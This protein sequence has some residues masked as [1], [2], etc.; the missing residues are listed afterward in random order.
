VTQTELRLLKASIDKR[1]QIETLDG[2]RMI[3]KVISVFDEGSDADLFYELV[4][5]SHPD[6]YPRKERV[7]GYSI[8]LK[9]IVSVRPASNE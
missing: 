7:G 8:P 9:D 1:V 2:E 6:L 3:A 5:T 4:S